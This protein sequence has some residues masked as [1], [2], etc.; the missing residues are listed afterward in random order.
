M[1]YRSRSTRVPRPETTPASTPMEDGVSRHRRFVVGALAK[2]LGTDV[3]MDDSGYYIPETKAFI[4][5]GLAE[6]ILAKPRLIKE[7]K[8]QV[9]R[10]NDD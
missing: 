9:R 1:S 10:I 5:K 3:T 6:D 8:E 4:D 7:L 2:E